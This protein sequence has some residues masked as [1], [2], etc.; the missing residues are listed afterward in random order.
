MGSGL[1]QDSIEA[2]FESC[3]L[4][5]LIEL[6][7][8]NT[9]SILIIGLSQHGE[10]KTERIVSKI[11]NFCRTNKKDADIIIGDT[12][13]D[14]THLALKLNAQVTDSISD[15]I[16]L[17]TEVE[18]TT[19]Q[20]VRVTGIYGDYFS[21][22]STYYWRK[23]DLIISANTAQKLPMREKLYRGIYPTEFEADDDLVLTSERS[24]RFL[25]Q[26]LKN[27]IKCLE[28][29][30]GRSLILFPIFDY[31]RTKNTLIYNLVN[32]AFLQTVQA[33]DISVQNAMKLTSPVMVFKAEN[34][35]NRIKRFVE[36]FGDERLKSKSEI[37]SFSCPYYRK[38]ISTVQT[39]E[40]KQK[41]TNKLIDRYFSLSQEDIL[42]NPDLPEALKKN[43]IVETRSTLRGLLMDQLM[44]GT[45]DYKL[46][47]KREYLVVTVQ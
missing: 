31:E 35:P 24:N 33:L 3:L 16:S 18:E 5:I 23:Y 2:F 7:N 40:D 11:T 20:K 12:N 44:K 15:D 27:A 29:K 30:H 19:P 41:Y 32:E 13:T 22:E 42:K 25:G 28:P 1:K 8:L 43:L 39:F 36:S 9:F 47:I 38:Y 34:I 21:F 45:N 17:S 6:Q 4:K 14:I 26:I 37:T 46:Q 10:L